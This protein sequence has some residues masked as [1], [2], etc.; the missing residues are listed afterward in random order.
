MTQDEKQKALNLEVG[1]GMFQKFKDDHIGIPNISNAVYYTQAEADAYNAELAGAL[2]STDPLTAEEAAA[3]NEAVTG[4]SKEAG[5]TLSSAEAAAYNATLEGAV[6]T[7]DIKTPAVPK[8]VKDYVD[9]GLNSK[10]DKTATVSDVSFN[11]STG[12][13]QETINGTTTDVCDVV[14]SGFRIT[15]DDVNGIDTFTA[16]GSATITDDNTNGLDIMNF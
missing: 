14:T 9:D 12:K 6:S 10:A 3:Y 13:L 2:N 1:Q 8:K 5:D 4:A 16:V 15:Q 11:S 7:S